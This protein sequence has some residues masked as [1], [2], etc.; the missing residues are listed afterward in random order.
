MMRPTRRINPVSSR[1]SAR[2]M[3]HTR[4]SGRLAKDCRKLFINDTVS[5]EYVPPIHQNMLFQV[6]IHQNLFCLFNVQAFISDLTVLVYPPDQLHL[7][8]GTSVEG[9]FQVT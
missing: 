8:P 7:A 3:N 2:K 1:F 6:L 5:Y 9:A 4:V